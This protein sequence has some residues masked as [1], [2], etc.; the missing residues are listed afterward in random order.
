M[1]RYSEVL[2]LPVIC[3]DSGKKAGIVKDIVFSPAEREVKA[4]LL[5]RKGVDLKKKVVL[6][7]EVLNI[8]G[9]A[10]ILDNDGCVADMGRSEYAKA[11]E[12]EGAILGRRIF[13]KT[14]EDMGVVKDVVFDWKTGRI[15]GLELS[16]GLLQDIMQGRRIMPLLGRVEFGEDNILVERE[17]VDE[18]LEA[19]GGLKRRL[20]D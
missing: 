3:A 17:A 15:E 19:T 5:E 16:D 6:L 9:D 12:D 20:Q 18:M 14:G 1:Q 10:V 8:G 11:F 4:L 2:G 13:S 7:K